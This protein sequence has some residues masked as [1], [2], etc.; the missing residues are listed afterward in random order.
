[1]PDLPRVSVV[2]ATVDRPGLLER[3]VSSVLGQDYAGEIECIV[4]Y[5]HVDIREF[6][7][8]PRR[9]RTLKFIQNSHRRGLPGGRNSG[10][11][12]ATGELLAFCDDDDIWLPAK[13][14]HQVEL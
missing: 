8:P 9:H 1:M 4:V 7:A 6:D 14:R 3:A 10:Y 11:D 13:L 5:D 12:A 2:I